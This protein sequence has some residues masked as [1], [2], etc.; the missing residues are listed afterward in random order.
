MSI[1]SSLFTQTRFHKL[2]AISGE[3]HEISTENE[4]DSS[5]DLTSQV[6]EFEVFNSNNKVPA[7][8]I[9][10]THRVENCEE[11]NIA[12]WKAAQQGKAE[13][14]EELL[15]QSFYGQC[16][17]NINYKGPGNWTALHVAANEGHLQ[18]CKF[19]TSFKN[20]LSIDAKSLKLETPLLLAC[21]KGHLDIAHLLV[22]SG[23][24]IHLQNDEGNSAIH[25]AAKEGHELVVSWLL[26]QRP[27]LEVKNFFGL[28][29][30]EVSASCC[31]KLFDRYKDLQEMQGSGKKIERTSFPVIEYA[32]KSRRKI[33]ACS[34][35]FLN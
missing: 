33:S 24:D 19:L 26:L 7:L 9:A 6:A 34:N 22:K 25:L 13:L 32:R 27:A 21:S 12:L 23:A 28:T 2:Q 35:I 4:S 17:A 5:E 16:Q 20:S 18:V 29:A 31:I 3:E 10:G 15:S 11:I 8:I 1:K 14:C 30:E